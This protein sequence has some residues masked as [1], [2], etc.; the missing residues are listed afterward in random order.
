MA[1][2][3][4]VTREDLKNVFEALGASVKTAIDFFYPVGSIYMSTNPTSP[5]ELFGGS[6][7]QIPVSRTLISAGTDAQTNVYKVNATGGATSVS[8]TPVGTVDKYALTIRQIPSHK[9][10]FGRG[11][12]NVNVSDYLGGS[13]ASY[14]LYPG[15]Q[16]VSGTT[17]YYTSAVGSSESHSHGFTG[18]K[19]S[20]STMQP[21]YAVYMWRRTA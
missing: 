8:Y 9:H 4:V 2:S 5:S 3:E 12:S 20:I 19:A 1:K 14:G 18:T 11:K 15:D 16:S 21:W 6:W 10:I 7:E 13:S 17:D